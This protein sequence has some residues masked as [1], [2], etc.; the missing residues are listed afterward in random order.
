MELIVDPANNTFTFS[1]DYNYTGG[2]NFA[3]N[4][5]FKAQNY[6]ED[7]DLTVDTIAIMMLN[8]TTSDN[9]IMY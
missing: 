5:K 6:D 1:D 3:Q 7:G 2:E 8:L 9:A 4:L